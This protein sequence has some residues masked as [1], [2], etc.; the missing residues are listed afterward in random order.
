MATFY[1]SIITAERHEPSY[2]RVAFLGKSFPEMLRVRCSSVLLPVFFV[3]LLVCEVTSVWSKDQYK[4]LKPSYLSWFEH[5]S[6]DFPLT[7]I[8]SESIFHLPWRCLREAG[9]VHSKDTESG[10]ESQGLIQ[11]VL[12]IGH[13]NTV[14]MSEDQASPYKP[15][16]SFSARAPSG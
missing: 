16:R 15:S 4:V 8:F 9:H 6:L 5:V 10:T 2:Y 3:L 1:S 13:L 12:I 14:C 7:G 11:P